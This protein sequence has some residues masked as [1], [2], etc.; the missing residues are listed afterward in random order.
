MSSSSHFNLFLHISISV[1]VCV[2]VCVFSSAQ[3]T[4]VEEDA[5]ELHTHD[6]HTH[7]SVMTV[8]GTALGS[9]AQSQKKQVKRRHRRKRSSCTTIDCVETNA[10]QEQ[11]DRS[12]SSDRSERG[13][14]RER[15]SKSRRELP[16]RLR[17]TEAPQSD[18]TSDDEEWRKSRSWSKEK[19]RRVR[20]RSG[21]SREIEVTNGGR[22]GEDKT[23]IMELQSVGSDE[24][25]ENQPSVEDSGGLKKRHSSRASKREG[26]LS[27]KEEQSRDKEKSYKSCS[28][29]SSSL[30][31][32]AEE[33]ITKRY[34]EKGSGSGDMSVP[35]P[36]TH[37]G[38]NGDISRLCSD[39]SELEVCRL[40]CDNEPVEMHST[41]PSSISSEW[42]DKSFFNFGIQ[43]WKFLWSGMQKIL[44]NPYLFWCVYIL[45]V[46]VC[47]CV[48]V[49]SATVKGMT[50][51]RW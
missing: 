8:T 39:D 6:K 26:Q 32:D 30:A 12:A 31:E 37:C 1:F 18:S 22:G 46:H 48:C 50:S 10:K 14:K 28:S 36:Q 5:S 42:R 3:P 24:G 25:K 38:M 35:T 4:L 23:E 29:G 47:L 16:P 20:R 51:A 34:Q 44:K 13:E 33:L 11:T 43:K 15:S 2:C 40:V 17:C 41:S 45:C 49:G 21:S 7:T 27:S 19:A 9:S